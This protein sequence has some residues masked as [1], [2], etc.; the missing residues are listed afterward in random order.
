M[1]WFK[2]FSDASSDEDVARL[3]A[4]FG[5]DGYMYYWRVLETIASQMK[6]VNTQTSLTYS[7]KIW[8]QMT[9]L[10][11]QKFKKIT[12]FI[13]TKLQ[14]SS[15]KVERKLFLF[16]EKSKDVLMINCPK[17]L[18][19]KDNHFKNSQNT[20][21]LLASKE[22]EVEVDK[23]IPP[24][25]PQRKRENRV[26]VDFGGE[27]LL[28]A[29][30]SESFTAVI[31]C[32]RVER[33]NAG[34]TTGLIG[35]N[36]KTG[37]MKLAAAIDKGETNISD[38]QRAIRNLLADPEKR[39]TYSLDGLANNFDVWLSRSPPDKQETRHLNRTVAVKFYTGTCHKC[40]YNTTATRSGSVE[41]PRCNGTIMITE[42]I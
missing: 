5:G 35:K 33:D 22:V 13:E 18:K 16:S 39:D 25:S 1:K 2:H 23:D 27:D 6:I 42:E 12:N 7:W 28:V 38:V 24:I 10:S 36:S 17:L 21:K 32:W 15:K 41:C 9:G 14:Q 11:Q 19:I 40:G 29:S 26:I 20:G 3:I 34:L 4:E 30:F 8:A 31:N 37:A